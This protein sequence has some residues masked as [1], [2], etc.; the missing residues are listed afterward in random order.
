M[1]DVATTTPQT[2]QHA[3]N[4]NVN[5]T[6]IIIDGIPPFLLSKAELVGLL[7]VTSRSGAFNQHLPNILNIIFYEGNQ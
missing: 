2:L 1:T 7:K 5:N 4:A 3:N 6:N